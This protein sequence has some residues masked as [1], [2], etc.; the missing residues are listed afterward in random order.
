MSTAS[1][2]CK[3]K[4]K[5]KINFDSC[6][7]K[8]WLNPSHTRLRKFMVSNLNVAT[9]QK[10]FSCSTHWVC[11]SCPTWSPVQAEFGKIHELKNYY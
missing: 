8:F 2:T 6:K 11:V 1:D 5:I 3:D 10:M 4:I 7:D 9:S